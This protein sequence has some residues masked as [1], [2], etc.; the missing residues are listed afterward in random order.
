MG[1]ERDKVSGS[2]LE[3]GCR[4]GGREESGHSVCIS[5]RGGGRW[6]EYPYVTLVTTVETIGEGSM[7]LFIEVV[8]PQTQ[9]LHATR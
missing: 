2:L 3:R 7:G 5:Q 6:E 4:V 8:L 9:R 1:K